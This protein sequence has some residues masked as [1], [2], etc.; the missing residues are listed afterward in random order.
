MNKDELNNFNYILILFIVKY[1]IISK[2]KNQVF[3]IKIFKQILARIQIFFINLW[4]LI[5]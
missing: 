5:T 3:L 2:F 1:Q 4:Q